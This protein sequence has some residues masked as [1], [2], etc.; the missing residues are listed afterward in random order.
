MKSGITPFAVAK[1]LGKGPRQLALTLPGIRTSG[2][3]RVPTPTKATDKGK[4]KKG[5]KN[6]GGARAGAES[7]SSDSDATSRSNL[8]GAWRATVEAA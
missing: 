5:G 8:A 3:R 4:G 1:G 7:D 6:R 2:G